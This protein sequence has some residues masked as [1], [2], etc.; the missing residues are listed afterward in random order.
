MEATAVGFRTSYL[1]ADGIRLIDIV[2]LVIRQP[3][4]VLLTSLAAAVVTA[5]FIGFILPRTYEGTVTLIIVSP[6]VTSELKPSSLT[7]QAFQKLLE[8]DAILEEVKRKVIEKGVLSPH[9]PFRIREEL[10]TR[11]FVSRLS[12]TTTLAPMLQLAVRNKSSEGAAVIANVW[13]DVFLMRVRELM[14]GSTSAH[15][16]F[17]DEEYPKS[18]ERLVRLETA[19]LA[20]AAGFSQR[21]DEKTRTWDEKILLQKNETNRLLAD[22]EVLT[23]AMVEEFVGSASLTIRRRQMKVLRDA[24]DD[25]QVEQTRVNSQL[26]QKNMQIEAARQQLSQMTAYVTLRKSVTDEALWKTLISGDGKDL[27]WKLLQEKSLVTQELNPVYNDLASRMSQMQ[28]DEKSM[29]P[30]AKQLEEELVRLSGQISRLDVE[31][32]ADD[33]KLDKLNHERSTGLEQ[34]RDKQ[35]NLL[36]DLVRQQ[37]RDLEDLKRERDLSL[38]QLDRGI[39]QE[40]DLNTELA[41][42]FNQAILAKA[43]QSAEDVRLGAPAVPMN[44]PLPRNLVLFS[45]LAAAGGLLV[46]LGFAAR[47]EISGRGG[48]VQTSLAP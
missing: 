47:R 5:L 22:Y 3:R 8:A 40:R 37:Q 17:V 46:G 13:A 34:L 19:R 10:D 45:L 2:R 26:Q 4:L 44:R 7:V 29:F 39:G 1:F 43:Q 15:V 14:A 30:R 9:D 16:K 48:S 25:I 41:K 42:N 18:R 20:E 12:E 28:V 27:D 21:L 35:A 33:G 36:A 23:N 32:R 11:I 38:A 6:K 31:L 24:Y